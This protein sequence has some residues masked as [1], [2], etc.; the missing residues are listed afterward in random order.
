MRPC[1]QPEQAS[2][3]VSLIK[4]ACRRAGGLHR[5]NRGRPPQHAAGQTQSERHQISP[6]LH[7]HRLQHRCPIIINHD[8]A[9]RRRYGAPHSAHRWHAGLCAFRATPGARIRSCRHPGQ[10]GAAAASA[11][12]RRRSHRLL[13]AGC[14][15]SAGGLS[16]MDKL[17]LP[18]T[19]VTPHSHHLQRPEGDARIAAPDRRAACSLAGGS[20]AC[21]ARTC[22]RPDS[23]RPRPPCAAGAAGRSRGGTAL[24][25]PPVQAVGAE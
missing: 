25:V 24:S 10:V 11:R 16:A 23:H 12:C 2:G 8:G 4:Q 15:H 17:A 7:D 1:G 21:C 5:T 18:L 19:F 20:G 22:A 14:L 3:Q 9:A 13:P 6:C